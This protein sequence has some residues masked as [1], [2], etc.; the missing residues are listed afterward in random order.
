M[1]KLAIITTGLGTYAMTN[2]TTK[3]ETIKATIETRGLGT[4]K[5]TGAKTTRKR[6]FTSRKQ[7]ANAYSRN[8]IIKD[9]N[10]PKLLWTRTDLTKLPHVVINLTSTQR[11]NDE[12]VRRYYNDHFHVT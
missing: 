8:P 6:T 7:L 9:V 12:A 10:R 2:E 3:A 11:F 5:K 1:G 4:S